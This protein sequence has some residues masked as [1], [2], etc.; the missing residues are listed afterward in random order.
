MHG[1]R[2][3][4]DDSVVALLADRGICLDVCPTSNVMLSVYSSISDHPL[5]RLLE[6]GVPCSV[7]ADDPLLFGT[8][9]LQE[10]ERCRTGLAMSDDTL[11]Q[12]ARMSIT[13]SAA[14]AS[15]VEPALQRIDAWRAELP[16]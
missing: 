8:D 7:G 16:A 14:P 9:I 12:V 15:I 4:E 6:A 2:A 13:A 5:A 11:A 10:Y 1:V 3:I